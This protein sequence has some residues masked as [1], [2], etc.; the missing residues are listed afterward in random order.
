MAS[1]EELKSK[2]QSVLQ[3]IQQRQ[4]SNENLHLQDGKLLSRVLH[5]WK[6][7]TGVGRDQARESKADDITADFPVG[8]H[9]TPQHRLLGCIR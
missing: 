6:R 3:V 5:R 2:Y 8:T 9:H 7:Q 4:V 1:L